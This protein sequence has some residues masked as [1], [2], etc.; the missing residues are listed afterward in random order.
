MSFSLRIELKSN[1]D[2]SIG[3]TFDK[4]LAREI[5]IHAGGMRRCIEKIFHIFYFFIGT[6][7]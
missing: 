4:S 7:T 1:F 3:G 5:G 6:Y 2:K